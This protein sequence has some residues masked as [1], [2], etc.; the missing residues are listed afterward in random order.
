[1]FIL[2]LFFLESIA[3]TIDEFGSMTCMGNSVCGY[4]Y[5]LSIIIHYTILLSRNRNRNR[6][7]L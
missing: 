7:S 4:Y 1:M 6:E 2:F 3:S 5:L